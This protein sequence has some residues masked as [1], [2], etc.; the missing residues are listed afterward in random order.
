M[1]PCIG[2]HCQT[3]WWPL[4]VTFSTIP[5]RT[6]RILPLPM[7]LISVSR[8][9]SPSGSRRSTSS[10]ACSGVVVGPILTPMGLA[11]LETNSMCAPSIWR[12]RSPTQ[13][14]CADEA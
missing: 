9:G 12:V 2:S 14:K 3:T 4:A 13:T 1:L 10:V 7:R 6:S 11:S 8:P 5:G